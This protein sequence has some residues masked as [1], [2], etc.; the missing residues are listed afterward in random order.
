M[1]AFL[2]YPP[3]QKRDA[4]A[5]CVF[6]STACCK[7][8]LTKTK[9]SAPLS[10]PTSNQTVSSK[11]APSC[12]ECSHF[13]VRHSQQSETGR[14]VV[15]PPAEGSARSRGRANPRGGGCAGLFGAMPGLMVVFKRWRGNTPKL[16]SQTKSDVRS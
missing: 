6:L 11:Q 9:K 13:S 14:S 16:K 5:S 15:A 3:S 10:L 4:E 7:D 12:L 8:H 1:L 2:I